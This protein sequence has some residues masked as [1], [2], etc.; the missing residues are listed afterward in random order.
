M[1][2]STEMVIFLIFFINQKGIYKIQ[3]RPGTYRPDFL[4]IW[5]VE[6]DVVRNESDLR[7]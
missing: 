2:N 1:A 5:L 6:P 7:T 4:D 3:D